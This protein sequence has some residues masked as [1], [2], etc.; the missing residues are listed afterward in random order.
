MIALARKKR[1]E[2]TYGDLLS[3]KRRMLTVSWRLGSGAE[4]GDEE[5]T[6]ANLGL[7]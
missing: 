4:T 7:Q 6:R 2:R 5:T 3:N 1:L